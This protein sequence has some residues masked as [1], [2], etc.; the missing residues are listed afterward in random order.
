METLME[1][2]MN[3]T[4]MDW[5]PHGINPH[6]FK[7]SWNQPWWFK[8]LKETLMNRTLLD[9]NPHGINPH[10]SKPSWNQPWWFKTLMEL[11][12]ME[13]LM[14]RTLLDWNTHGINPH[15][16]KPSRK[17]SWIPS[18][19]EPS[20]T[21]TLMEK[22]PSCFQTLMEST[23]RSNHSCTQNMFF[24]TIWSMYVSTSP[25]RSMRISSSNWCCHPTL[26][27]CFET[28]MIPNDQIIISQLINGWP[29]ACANSWWVFVD[30]CPGWCSH[31][32]DQM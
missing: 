18:W 7:P 23:L 21:E 2:P 31:G 9:W 1:T 29:M 13:T 26:I 17:P 25:S 5:N 16:S 3:R 32:W 20:W 6:G 14:N 8:T 22:H 28:K 12:F 10:G 4:L 24:A 11:A 19:N 27:G 15:G 30:Q